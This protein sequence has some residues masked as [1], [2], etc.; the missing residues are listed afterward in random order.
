MWQRGRPWRSLTQLRGRKHTPNNRLFVCTALLLLPTLD[1]GWALTSTTTRVH[2]I[3]SPWKTDDLLNYGLFDFR[4][5]TVAFRL[6][7][8]GGSKVSSKTQ[9]LKNTPLDFCVQVLDWDH[10]FQWFLNQ[11]GNRS[12]PTKPPSGMPPWAI[13][14]VNKSVLFYISVIYAESG[15]CSSL[16]LMTFR[17]DL[18]SSLY[19]LF[20]WNWT[21]V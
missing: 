19:L 6:F 7:T 9:W 17:R 2:Y 4:I 15:F 3:M 20:L 12:A 11:L 16:W 13:A 8:G 1:G 14:D 5:V 10:R 18:F 21:H